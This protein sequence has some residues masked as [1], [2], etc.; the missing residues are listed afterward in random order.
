MSRSLVGR[1]LVALVLTVFGLAHAP[2]SSAN[3][4]DVLFADDFAVFDSSFGEPTASVSVADHALVVK[5]DK[6]QWYRLPYQS[7]IY[8]DVDATVRVQMPTANAPTG[9]G[10]GL[11]FWTSD[12]SNSYVFEIS[13]HGTYAVRRI[14]PDLNITHISWR[15]SD[16]INTQAGAWNELRVVTHGDRATV[17]INGQELATL[18]G[19]MPQGGSLVGLFAESF[20][21]AGEGRFMDL[22]VA[23]PGSA[24]E[25]LSLEVSDPG[26]ILGD[27]FSILDPAWGAPSDWM[28]L[29]DGQLS[30]SFEPSQSVT[31]LNLGAIVTGDMDM[32]VTA[33][34]TGEVGDV[35]NDAAAGLVFWAKDYANFYMLQ[36]M[37]DGT[38][39]VFRRVGDRWLTPMAVKEVPAAAKFDL[40]AGA[41]LRVVTSGRRATL[42]I[43]GVEV[44]V[45]SGQ[46]PANES[47]IGLYAQS[48]DAA[49]ATL[50]DNL[51]IRRVAVQ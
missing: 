39:I 35:N 22:K 42:F 3:P 6:Q 33:R 23:E 51:T 24:P 44:G 29:R 25:T 32:T 49:G 5:L 47:S 41:E 43:N 38:M 17:F 48:G 36:V 14:T 45:I 26:M 2:R 34:T 1:A 19:R 31:S 16:A 15:T 27:D 7:M 11:M 37:D 4:G 50:F 28:S 10:L 9:V 30:Y 20:D 21:V 12:Y 40:T 46:P 8:D 13:D 18:R